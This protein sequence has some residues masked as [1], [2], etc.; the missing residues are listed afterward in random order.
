MLLSV[1][2][3]NE[4]QIYTVYILFPWLFFYPGEDLQMVCGFSCEDLLSMF[5]ELKGLGV[6][7]KELSN[8]LRKLVRKKNATDCVGEP[9]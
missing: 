2:K 6:V 1:C 3:L 9:K 5:K 7:V 4:K 8:E